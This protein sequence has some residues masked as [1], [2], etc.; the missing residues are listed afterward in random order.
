[1]LTLTTL[2]YAFSPL[3][4]PE[5]LLTLE[6]RASW[7]CRKNR[8]EQLQFPNTAPQWVCTR[9]A[10]EA[11]L[12]ELGVDQVR[13]RFCNKEVPVLLELRGKQLNI[14][15]AKYILGSPAAPTAQLTYSHG[16]PLQAE[17]VDYSTFP[18]FRMRCTADEAF[19]LTTPYHVDGVDW[20]LEYHCT[21]RRDSAKPWTTGQHPFS[22]TTHTSDSTACTA[23]GK[24]PLKR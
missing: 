13:L 19:S 24:N 17:T 1:M 21:S 22:L 16:E 9:R 23:P 15:H 8:I 2:A 4:K 10:T 12:I 18:D 3:P 6:E 20:S 14:P 5:P 11:S 7:G